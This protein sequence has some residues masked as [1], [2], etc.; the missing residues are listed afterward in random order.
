MKVLAVTPQYLPIV[1]GIEIF[2]DMLV[3]PLRLRAVETVVVTDTDTFGRLPERDVVNDT[4]IHRLDFL[5]AM[6]TRG[7]IGPLEVLQQLS[8]ILAAE[9]PDLIH[10]H[11]AVQ[12][13]AWYLDRLFRRLSLKP[14]FIVTQH[15]VLEPVDCLKVVRELLLKADALTAVSKAAL[16]SAIQFSNRTAFSTVIYNGIRTLDDT[17]GVERTDPGYRLMCVGRLQLE[18]GFDVAIAALAKVRSQGLDADLTLIGWGR[19]R[20][21]LQKAAVDHA[22]ADH[23]RFEGVLDR[24][25]TLEAIAGCSLVLIPSRMR[26]GF[27][28]VAAEAALCGVPCVASRVGGLPEVVEDGATGLLVT[29]DDPDRLASAV[30][31]LLRDPQRLRTLG[32]NARRRAQERFDMDRC[33]DGYLKLYRELTQ[34]R[35][36]VCG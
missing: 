8:G 18:K 2:V 15:G 27:S 14:P 25:R 17:V 10:M 33:V 31:D 4:V 5:K 20:M 19:E 26:E 28:L 13:S 35:D 7:A 16:Q 22:V 36:G 23:V 11:S 32:A 34:L 6:Q 29:P 30:I 9:Q 24:R 21:S 12:P 1:G 3:Q